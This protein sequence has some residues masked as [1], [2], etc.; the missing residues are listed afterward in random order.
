MGGYLCKFIEADRIPFT[1]T[2]SDSCAEVSPLPNNLL[3]TFT[4]YDLILIVLPVTSAKN[5]KF[6]VKG[7]VCKFDSAN[8]NR[9]VLGQIYLNYEE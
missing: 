4:D 8:I 9:P 7:K 6:M 1:V 3:K 2:S 5:S